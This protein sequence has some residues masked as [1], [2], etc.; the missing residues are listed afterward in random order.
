V[1]VLAEFCNREFVEDILSRRFED[2]WWS[3]TG[4]TGFDPPR[5]TDTPAVAGMKTG[6]IELGSWGDEVV[7][8]LAAVF[9][10]L[11]CHHCT[12]FVSTRITVEMSAVTITQ[13]PGFGSVATGLQR[14]AENVQFV[15][16][17]AS[18]YRN[19]PIAVGPK[20]TCGGG[21]LP[22][23][24]P[25]AGA[26]SRRILDEPIVFAPSNGNDHWFYHSGA[27]TKYCQVIWQSVTEAVDRHVSAPTDRV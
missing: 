5:K 2:N 6:K 11:L 1:G 27:G 10:K 22:V 15:S 14:R 24:R 7:S 12:H 16:G 13:E 18:T 8:L 3:H 25:Q 9:E 26:Y 21:L 17:H 19:E 4:L 23:G 20:K